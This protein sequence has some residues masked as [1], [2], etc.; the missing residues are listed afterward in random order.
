[1]EDVVTEEC[2]V[3]DQKTRWPY[4]QKCKRQAR[5]KVNRGVDFG[6]NSHN[7][8]QYERLC[9]HHAAMLREGFGDDAIVRIE[10]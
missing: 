3:Q 5:Y 6:A 8:L 9:A 1:M 2:Q 10:E 7:V 4:V